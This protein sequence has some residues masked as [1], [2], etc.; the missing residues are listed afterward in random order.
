[1]SAWT[2]RWAKSLDLCG[3]QW[4]ET[5]QA[6]SYPSKAP[7]CRSIIPRDTEKAGKKFLTSYPLFVAIR[8]A[9]TL[10]QLVVDTVL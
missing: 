10:F 8:M 1:M 4:A 6:I 7:K 9:T 2:F 5:D 3:L